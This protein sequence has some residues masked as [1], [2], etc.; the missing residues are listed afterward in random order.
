VWCNCGVWATGKIIKHWYN[1][2]SWPAGKA[3]P[4]QVR[5]DDGRE[6]YAPVDKDEVV[7]NVEPANAEDQ[8]L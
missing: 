5:L 4:Y 8:V 3:V 1:E 2:E 7:T 6:I